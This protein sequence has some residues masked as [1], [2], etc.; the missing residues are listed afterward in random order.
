MIKI[1]KKR[2][3]VINFN[4]FFDLLKTNLKYFKITSTLSLILI[5]TTISDNI[6]T[7]FSINQIFFL[8]LLISVCHL[9]STGPLGTDQNFVDPTVVNS[10]T[11]IPA[12]A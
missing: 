10:A 3:Y 7:S 4:K 2:V 9:E 11:T 8:S 1:N 12:T 6:M 5:T